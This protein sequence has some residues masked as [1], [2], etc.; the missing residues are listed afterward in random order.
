MFALV[1]AAGFY[2]SCEKVIDIKL[3]NKPVIVLSNNDGCIVAA[4]PIAKKMGAPKFEPYFKVKDFVRNNKVIVRSSNYELYGDLSK[5]FM[6]CAAQFSPVQYIYSIDECFLD[7]HGFTMMIDWLDYGWK[8][9]RTVWQ[10]TKIPVCV[11]I[12]PT[13]TLAKAANFSSKNIKGYSGVLAMNTPEIRKMALEQMPVNKV[14]G[15][16][17]QLAKH[18]KL[19]GVETAW[20]LAQQ[21]PKRMR[22]EFNINVERTVRELNGK[23]CLSWD[24]KRA[25][26]KE[27]FSTRSVGKRI[28]T[29]IE[30]KAALAFHANIVARK[31]RKQNTLIKELLVFA[32]SSPHDQE[33]YYSRSGLHQFITGT[34]DTTQVSAAATALASQIYNSEVRF[35][36][37]G[38]GAIRLH[39]YAPHQNDLF[40][41]NDDK[42]ELMKCMDEINSLWG[43]DTVHLGAQGVSQ[44]FEMKRDLLSPQYTTRWEHLPKFK[45]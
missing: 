4:C 8:I 28:T 36:K 19:L 22:Q 45:C 11:G 24:E 20:D 29:L 3:R 2:A 13:L 34:I 1:D 7:L 25:T 5:R 30:L 44:K 37:V 33:S 32:Q 15:I 10:E 42:V 18:L 41:A 38:V 14:W 43:V 27:I 40:K 26:K 12:A 16:G 17:R 6:N 9:R 23:P 39:P 31:A 35:Y 21:P